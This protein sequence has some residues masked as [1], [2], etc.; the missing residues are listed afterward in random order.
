[1]RG[2][3]HLSNSMILLKLQC[4]VVARVVLPDSVVLTIDDVVAGVFPA[5]KVAGAHALM[6][7]LLQLARDG[8][9]ES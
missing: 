7:V 2:A 3:G 6:S 5:G 4:T 8:V 9:A 1:M